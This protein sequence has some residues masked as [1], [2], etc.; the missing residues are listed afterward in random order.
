MPYFS[1]RETKRAKSLIFDGLA[2]LAGV[3]LLFLYFFKKEK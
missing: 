1:H 3:L 2:V